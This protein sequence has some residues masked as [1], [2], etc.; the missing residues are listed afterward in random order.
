MRL[1][2]ACARDSAARMYMKRI[3]AYNVI[4]KLLRQY[5]DSPDVLYGCGLAL[6]NMFK[7]KRMARIIANDQQ[8]V[9]QLIAL[10]SDFPKSEVS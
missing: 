2:A 8:L 6:V 1:L 9:A 4:H 3:Q 7:S 10:I 5:Y